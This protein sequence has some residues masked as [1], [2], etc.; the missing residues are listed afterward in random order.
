MKVGSLGF[1]ILFQSHKKLSHTCLN[2][3][4]DTE[5]FPLVYQAQYYKTYKI[6][7][8]TILAALCD[9]SRWQQ[10]MWIQTLG[11]KK[12][13]KTSKAAKHKHWMGQGI[14]HRTDSSNPNCYLGKCCQYIFDWTWNKIV[15]FG[16]VSLIPKPPGLFNFNLFKKILRH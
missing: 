2:T 6:L 16:L 7:W 4:S 10:G 1:G 9:N 14:F 13:P 5:Y 8:V 12:H 15:C 3:A 11:K